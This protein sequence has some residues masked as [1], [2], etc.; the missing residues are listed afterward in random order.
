VEGSFI[1]GDELIG[2][3]AFWLEKYTLSRVQGEI[4]ALTVR[5]GEFQLL[6]RACSDNSLIQLPASAVTLG[7][8]EG[9]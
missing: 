9:V 4:Y 3:R 1:G 2:E 5:E 6:L 7:E 8:A